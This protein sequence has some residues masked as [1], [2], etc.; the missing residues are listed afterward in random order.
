[1]QGNSDDE[2]DDQ[3]EDSN[4]W[5]RPPRLNHAYALPKRPEHFQTMLLCY[6]KPL[7]TG[8]SL[9]GNTVFRIALEP[10]AEQGINAQIICE[11][12]A[13]VLGEDIHAVSIFKE[14]QPTPPSEHLVAF[15]DL[16]LRVAVDIEPVF[17]CRRARPRRGYAATDTEAVLGEAIV[18]LDGS[19]LFTEGS[20][21]LQAV[22]EQRELV[23][24]R[25][26]DVWLVYTKLEVFMYCRPERPDHDLLDAVGL[27]PQAPAWK[28][29]PATK[30][31]GSRCDVWSTLLHLPTIKPL[32]DK[33]AE[34]TADRPIPRYQMIVDP[35]RFVCEGAAGPCWV[36]CEFDIGEDG[37]VQL[38]GGARSHR[39]PHLAEQ[40]A[41]PLLSAA[42]P[43]LAKLRRPQLLLEG[44]RLQVVLKA[45]RIIL[46]PA[47]ED[48]ETEYLGLWHVDGHREDV[49][50][51]VLYYY[52]VDASLHGG[53]IEFCGRE[54]LD[55]LGFGDCDNNA[56]RFTRREIRRA[57][58]GD[59]S[60]DRTV[61]NC[62]VP[63]KQGTMLVF[64]NYQM[65]HRVLRLVSNEPAE[66][67]R[68]FV[69]LFILNPAGKSLVPA[70]CALAKG[71]MLQKTFQC[72]SI[73]SAEVQRILEFAGESLSSSREAERRDAMLLEQLQPS[74]AFVGMQNVHSTGNGCFTMVGWL[75]NALRE[76]QGGDY[77]KSFAESGWKC[78]SRFNKPPQ[79]EHGLSAAF[80]QQTS[81][82]CGTGSA[83]D[84][85]V[86]DSEQAT[87]NFKDD[88]T[89][90]GGVVDGK[91]EGFG[92][93][94]SPT[95]TYE[96]HWKDDKQNGEGKHTWS[97]GRSY[98]GQY[99]NGRFSGKGKMVWRTD[100]GTMIYEGDYLDDAKHGFG[101]FTWPNGN[102]YEGGWQNGKRHGKAT[103]ITSTGKQKV[104]FWHDDKFVKWEG[105]DAEPSQA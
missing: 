10:M 29:P 88:A 26:V 93:Y 32:L 31:W 59:A 43:L 34:L 66:A 17:I 44:R 8:I 85:A 4:A 35:N 24:G 87:L 18:E 30:R 71:Y 39:H 63:I 23:T 3:S 78:F 37:S 82:D 15:H 12:V 68:D 41:T 104:G 16:T 67:S 19:K 69:A 73:R 74:G 47:R 53:D 50:A 33:H 55:V 21:I 46:P 5:W 51:V 92:T 13:E 42:M 40:V 72:K 9:A 60:K 56:S 65:V 61:Q 14:G 91:R 20:T 96:G 102:V 77:V 6:E 11:K 94:K 64:S 36:P 90:T 62:R 49:V 28:L 101:K 100:K 103:F 86:K 81:S 38:V 70:R 27:F 48:D 84:V 97:D 2:D 1:S 52:H 89:Y 95:E 7:L 83:E 79:N 58:R 80:S 54:P 22:Q 99:V 76:R 57:F 98:E 105:D 75:H 45:Q 25:P